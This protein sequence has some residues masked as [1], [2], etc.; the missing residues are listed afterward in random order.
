MPLPTVMSKSKLNLFQRA[1]MARAG[2][3]GVRGAF[4]GLGFE[5]PEIDLTGESDVDA[6][7]EAAFGDNA[8]SINFDAE[9][10]Y[11]D[12][13]PPR[14]TRD[15]VGGGESSYAYS[16][17]DDAAPYSSGNAPYSQNRIQT[18]TAARYTSARGSTVDSG[19]GTAAA[20]FGNALKDIF[21]GLFGGKAEASTQ[22]QRAPVQK[23]FPWGWVVGG[24]AAFGGVALLIVLA[25]GGDKK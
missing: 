2:R 22:Q 8:E 5:G 14:S 10:V 17:T 24:A 16:A 25:K 11:G 4:S 19:G 3:L 12:A 9:T 23:P 1:A 18:T 20:D 13:P 7:F 6:E 21:G 15:I